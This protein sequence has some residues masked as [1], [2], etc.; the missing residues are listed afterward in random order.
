MSYGLTAPTKLGPTLRLHRGEWLNTAI[1][2]WSWETFG[3]SRW[4]LFRA[5]GLET[6]PPALV[7]SLAVGLPAAVRDNIAEATGISPA[8]LDAATMRALDGQLVNLTDQ[9]ASGTTSISTRGPWSWRA[10]TRYCPDCL[11]E[12]PGV[13]NLAWRSPWTFFCLIHERV[14]LDSCPQCTRPLTETRDRT[15]RL[16]DPSTCQ[17]PLRDRDGKPSRDVCGGRLS[18]TWDQTLLPTTAWPAIAQ[19]SIILSTRDGS[20]WDLIRSLQAAAVALRA[21]QLPE[22]VAD[23]AGVPR[24]LLSGMLDSE[25]HAGATP[26]PNAVAMAALTGAAFHLTQMPPEAAAP[27][28]RTVTFSRA[29][30]HVPR[31][32]GHG[33]GSVR[34]LL[35]RWPGAPPTLRRHVLRALDQDFG[36][37]QRVLHDTTALATT[38]PG[39]YI[40]ARRLSGVP[41]LCWP[42]IAER[43]DVGGAVTGP[44]LQRGLSVAIR[45]TGSGSAAEVANDTALKRALRPTMLGTPRQTDALLQ[46]VGIVSRQLDD[47]G[48]PVDYRR[49]VQL[50]FEGLLPMSDWVAIANASGVR[51]GGAR[52][53]IHA[54]RYAFQR[55]TGTTLD[56]APTALASPRNRADGHEYASFRLRITEELQQHLDL[57]LRSFLLGHGVNEPVVWSPTP[58]RVPE[59]LFVRPPTA[60]RVAAALSSAVDGKAGLARHAGVSPR[61]LEWAVESRP[62]RNTERTGKSRSQPR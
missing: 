30:S 50:P 12:R 37:G 8:A 27:I 58:P 52:R 54:R 45:L 48:C 11:I 60:A 9:T 7:R 19:A 5:F 42:E 43:L 61:Q 16:F 3:A 57:Y 39:P 40:A 23:L 4:A 34:E 6:V 1:T 14:L 2:R 62:P 10:G 15:Q 31:G 36:V 55:L 26:P 25:A 28:I 21:A 44:A 41:D 20:A 17:T 13:F 35:A 56:N 22:L 47:E 38:V 53:L 49:R 59:G 32:A 51:I 33:P 46:A 18:D 29:P 24:D